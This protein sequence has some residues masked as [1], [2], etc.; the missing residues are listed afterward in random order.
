MSSNKL[1]PLK[2]KTVQASLLTIEDN[3]WRWHY[4]Y[5]HLNFNGLRTLHQNEMVTG[6]PEITPPSKEKSKA[7]DAFKSFKTLAENETD[8]KIKTLKTD[9]GGEFCSKEFDFLCREKGIKRHLTTAYMP[10]QNGVPKKFCPKAVLWSVHILNRSPTFSIKNMT[11]QE[12]W[13]GKKPSVDHFK[14]FGCI[15]YAYILDEKRKKLDDKNEKCIFLGVSEAS[16]AYRLHNLVTTK[17]VISRGE[18]PQPA[19][20]PHQQLE[21]ERGYNLRD[22]KSSK[23]L[24]W[25][26]DY[27]VNFTSS[28][29]DNAHFALFVDSDPITYDEAIKVK[30]WREAMDNEIKSIEKNHTW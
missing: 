9:R 12:A 21:E 16:K 28:D 6:L 17:I 7:F 26:M 4:I 3:S 29:D 27:N 5:G 10:Q 23:K 24:A 25:M 8:K 15:A 20:Q 30:K 11:P 18:S 2:I 14:V 19:A 22:E 1:F 13:S